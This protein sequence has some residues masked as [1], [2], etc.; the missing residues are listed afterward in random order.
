MS[1]LTASALRGSTAA[2]TF[3]AA[4]LR[5]AD[6]YSSVGYSDAARRAEAAA[7]AGGVSRRCW[8]AG[9]RSRPAG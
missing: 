6:V 4:A 5:V 8:A 1:A 2:G 9:A 7:H 3:R